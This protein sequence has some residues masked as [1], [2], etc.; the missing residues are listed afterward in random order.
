MSDETEQTDTEWETLFDSS[1]SPF[2]GYCY[3]ADQATELVQEFSYRTST[4]F[5]VT[6]STRDFGMYSILGSITQI[7]SIH[8]KN[9][10]RLHNHVGIVDG[11]THSYYY[12]QGSS[13]RVLVSFPHFSLTAPQPISPLHFPSSS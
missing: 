5:V 1:E 3:T 7:V 12:N 10:T 9:S 4:S 11:R 8:F 6:R 2:F 13:A